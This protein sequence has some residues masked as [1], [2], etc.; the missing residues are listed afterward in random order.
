MTDTL[1][2]QYKFFAV[3]LAIAMLGMTTIA[4]IRIMDKRLNS[5]E[6]RIA[7]LEGKR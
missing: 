5:L 3:V 4:M 7:V 2:D 1:K 6:A